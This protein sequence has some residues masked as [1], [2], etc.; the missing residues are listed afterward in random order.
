MM[1]DDL[2]IKILT[3]AFF[4]KKMKLRIAVAES[5]TSGKLADL[6]TSLAGSSTWFDMG[7]V[8]YSN[9]SKK[10][11]LGVSS[12]SIEKH[13]SVSGVVACEMLSGLEKIYLNEQYSSHLFVSITGIA[14]PT[15]GSRHKPKGLVWFGFYT[16]KETIC[17]K[18]IFSG[19]RTQIRKLAVRWALNRLIFESVRKR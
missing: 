14:G 1:H 13:G 2:L 16:Q 17:E 15:G 7:L 10:S 8:C 3:F 18:K 11:V 6:L 12:T 5:C 19:S 9:W 4:A